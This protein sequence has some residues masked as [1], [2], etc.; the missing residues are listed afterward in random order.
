MRFKSGVNSVPT[1]FQLIHYFFTFGLLLALTRCTNEPVAPAAM[2][3]W[4][5]LRVIAASGPQEGVAL[6]ADSEHTLAAWPGDV[7][8][9]GLRLLDLSK[10]GE[11]LTLPLGTTPRKVSL[12]AA[13]GHGLQLLWLDQTALGEIR[14]VGA[15]LGADR[16]VERGPTTISTQNVSDYTALYGR[17]GDLLTFWVDSG[18]LTSSLYFQEVDNAGRPRQALRLSASAARP[19]AAFDAQ[20][21][22]RVAWLEPGAPHEWTIHYAAF[23]GSEPSSSADTVIGSIQLEANQGIDSFNLGTDATHVYC[24]WSIITVRQGS[25][26]S[27]TLAGLSFPFTDSAATRPLAFGHAALAGKNLRWPALLSQAGSFVL[28]AVS[29]TDEVTKR[30]SPL[31]LTLTPN[32]VNAVQQ[33]IDNP[34]AGT[35]MGKTALVLAPDGRLHAA[36]PILRENGSAAIYYTATGNRAP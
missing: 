35:I 27:T 10:P 36:W 21:I 20:G 9:P 6:L 19:S 34:E 28:V 8:T 29:A 12:F 13:P 33:V 11:P 15:L 2:R 31:I 4:Q 32:G 1:V 5:A 23:P 16:Q 17:S 25:G 14:L 7:Q 30:D 22:L 3:P 26:L 24:L 18:E